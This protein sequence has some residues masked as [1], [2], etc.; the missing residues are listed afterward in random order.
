MN[1]SQQ[2]RQTAS[3]EVNTLLFGIGAGAASGVVAG[4]WARISMRAVAVIS[5]IRP[6]FSREGTFFILFLF[7]ILGGILGL[8]F[9][10]FQWLIN[11][12]LPLKGFVYGLFFSILVAALFLLNDLTGELALVS[13]LTIVLLFS[14]IMLAYGIL[15]GTGMQFLDRAKKSKTIENGQNQ[16]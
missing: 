10:L 4:I 14:P 2:F 13:P 11:W 16:D 7:A 15:L 6:E 1:I 12:P 9:S 3:F 5:E 8:I